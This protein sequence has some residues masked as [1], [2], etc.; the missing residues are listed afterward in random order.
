MRQYKLTS[1]DDVPSEKIFKGEVYRLN[2]YVRQKP[3]YDSKNPFMASISVKENLFKGTDRKCLHI[4]L[5]ITD[6]RLRYEAGD[7]VAIYP[8]NDPAIVNRIGEL[9]DVDLDQTFSLINIDEDA[10]K[11]HPFPC[12]TTF[13]TALSYYLD[14]TSL[15]TTQLIK[16]LAQY[17]T[18]ENEKKSLQLMA[19][20]SEEGKAFYNSFIRDDH[21]DL[22]N[23]L[24][25]ISSLKPPIDHVMELLPRLQARYYSISSSPKVNPNTIHVTC[26]VVEYETKDGRLCKGVT[27]NWLLNKPISQDLKPKVP[28]FVRK[29]QFRLPFKFQ[30]S[31]LMIGPGT[32]LAPFR[33]FLQERDFYRKEGRLVGK[34]ILYY[35]CRKKAEDYLYQDELE[36]YETN[37]T[38]TKLNVAFSRDQSQKVYV[39]HLLKKDAALVWSII[40]EGGHIY[41]CGYIIKYNVFN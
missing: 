20:A 9:L 18:D 14:I 28:I 1:L 19:S 32:G 33:G 37:G 26:T 8:V 11:K 40:K 24:E 15:P 17:A 16:E 5:D 23:L 38:L 21:T 2:S 31:I 39:T 6:S 10:S 13:R 36:K 25:K 29:S 27:T 35:G 41:V 22:V 12:P 7:H 34:S 30:T 4:E 3:P